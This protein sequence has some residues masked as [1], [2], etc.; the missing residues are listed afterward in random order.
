M[1]YLKCDST[2][3]LK[4]THGGSSKVYVSKR[5]HRLFKQ[6]PS[7]SFS[8]RYLVFFAALKLPLEMHKIRLNFEK[9]LKYSWE[10]LLM[11]GF[12]SRIDKNGRR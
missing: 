5:I 6:I 3:F 4:H 8:R 2:V 1:I 12:F 7:G 9:P 11:D 10:V